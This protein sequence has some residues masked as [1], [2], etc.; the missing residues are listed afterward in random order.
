MIGKNCL[1]PTVCYLKKH[2]W[3]QVKTRIHL[4]KKVLKNNLLSLTL[5]I[6]K[7]QSK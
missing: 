5:K 6:K 2:M 4:C 1:A 3:L 7:L